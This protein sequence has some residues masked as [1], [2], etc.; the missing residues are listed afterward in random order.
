MDPFTIGFYAIVCAGL[1]AVAPRVPRLPVRLAIGAVV[2]VIAASV[3]PQIKGMIGT[4]AVML[5]YMP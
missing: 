1:S 5:G 2:G 3:L 4:S